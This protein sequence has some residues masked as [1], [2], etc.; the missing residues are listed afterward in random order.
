MALRT[1]SQYLA[2]LRDGR[3]VYLDGKRVDD[4]TDEEGQRVNGAWVRP[5]D[6]QELTWRRL[7][8]QTIAR[9]TGGLFGRQPDYVALFHLGMLDIKRDFSRG[10]E[11]FERNIES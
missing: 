7:L 8:T 4:V 1:G 10:D 6:R 5:S 11:R 3:E 2:A 9:H